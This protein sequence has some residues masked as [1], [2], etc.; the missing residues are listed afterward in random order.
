M[1]ENKVPRLFSRQEPLVLLDGTQVA[2][3]RWAHLAPWDDIAVKQQG[4]W[5]WA[6]P[7]DYPA[8]VTVA[9]AHYLE[10]GVL[11]PHVGCE[12]PWGHDGTDHE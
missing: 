1:S 5:V 8:Y 7:H 12:K 10:M 2:Q 9:T 3:G 11:C 6:R 4:G